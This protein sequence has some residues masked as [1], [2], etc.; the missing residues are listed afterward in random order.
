MRTGPLRG[1]SRSRSNAGSVKHT[2]T[3]NSA[4]SND[5]LLFQLPRARPQNFISNW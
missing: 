4:M 1:R 2:Q 5:H 3:Y